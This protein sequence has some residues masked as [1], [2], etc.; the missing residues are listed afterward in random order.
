MSYEYL[1]FAKILTCFCIQSIVSNE[2]LPNPRAQ[3]TRVPLPAIQLLSA[4]GFATENPN[5]LVIWGDDI[6]VWNIGACNHGMIG[7]ETPNI[8]R[9]AREG[10][11]LTG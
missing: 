5:V 11:L 7:Y 10:A 6:G 2:C 3:G 4:P 8:D 1:Y 9:L